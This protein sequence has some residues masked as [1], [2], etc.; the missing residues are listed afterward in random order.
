MRI[1][2]SPAL[3]R[4]IELETVQAGAKPGLGGLGRV[5]L[6]VSHLFPYVQSC[7][8]CNGTGEGTTSTYCPSCHGAGAVEIIGAMMDSRP[9][10][11]APASAMVGVIQGARRPPRFQPR[12]PAG[13]VS[14]PPM[15]K[16]LV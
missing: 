1:H 11:V 10:F 3:I 16:G 12:F 2:G 6:T 15:C 9:D 4:R 7:A 5:D 14:L 8:I 13:I